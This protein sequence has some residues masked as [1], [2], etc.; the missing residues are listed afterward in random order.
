MTDSPR[1]K[2]TVA[3][4]LRRVV[5]DRLSSLSLRSEVR[6]VRSITSHQRLGSMRVSI[7]HIYTTTKR[8]FCF[9]NYPVGTTNCIH[10][11]T[12]FDSVPALLIQS[13]RHKHRGRDKVKTRDI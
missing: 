4:T 6:N 10:Q 2:D 3:A 8:N 12:N 5:R 9:T 13:A 1:P 7:H 11:T